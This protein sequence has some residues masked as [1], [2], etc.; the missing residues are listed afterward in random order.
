MI[1]F[2]MTWR[3]IKKVSK[4]QSNINFFFVSNFDRPIH[5]L[6]QTRYASD[7]K[8]N[9]DD[10]LTEFQLQITLNCNE[11]SGMLS[12][13]LFLFQWIF[14]SSLLMCRFRSAYAAIDTQYSSI[15]IMTFDLRS[16]HS[17]HLKRESD[18]DFLPHFLIDQIVLSCFSLCKLQWLIW[19]MNTY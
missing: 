8:I 5:A 14:V 19:N 18:C 1:R 12:D 17:I 16:F 11:H 3:A 10:C 13:S 4:V 15:R 2:Y 7:L 9:S 6:W